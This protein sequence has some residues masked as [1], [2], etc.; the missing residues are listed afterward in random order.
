M[1]AKY[2]LM[3]CRRERDREGAGAD[4]LTWCLAKRM[5]CRFWWKRPLGRSNGRWKNNI[6][7][8]AK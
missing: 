8:D 2:R 4:S 7:V 5:G 3:F 1:R 6:K